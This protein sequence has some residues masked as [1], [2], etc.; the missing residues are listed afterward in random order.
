MQH[1]TSLLLIGTCM[2]S[3]LFPLICTYL[4]LEILYNCV[5]SKVLTLVLSSFSFIF[6]YLLVQKTVLVT[7]GLQD[8]YD[9]ILAIKEVAFK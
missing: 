9:K 2:L 3:Y 8:I 6:T 1:L 4:I 5:D 7:L